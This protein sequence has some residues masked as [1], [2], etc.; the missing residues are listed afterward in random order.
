MSSNTPHGQETRDVV[1]RLW[2]TG[3]SASKIGRELNM[4]KNMIIG[5]AHR[6][7]LP[8]RP[9][10]IT[11][12]RLPVTN[13]L[14]V[15]AR[16]R[17]DNGIPIKSIAAFLGITPDAF[18]ARRKYLGWPPRDPALS[19]QARWILKP[20][21]RKYQS[22]DGAKERKAARRK[23]SVPGNPPAKAVETRSAPQG[24]EAAPVRAGGPSAPV[25]VLW[26]GTCQ[27]PF[28]EPGTK[29]F[30]F[31]DAPVEARG[32]SYCKDHRKLCWV[33]VRDVREGVAA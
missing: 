30:R 26:P 11:L 27:Y 9:C 17:W 19:F 2:A 13:P 6:M 33:R 1:E 12:S 15:E 16:L 4:T 29:S 31:C 23:G 25:T 10:P 3:L 20:Y 14:M 5:L 21:A 24:G 18:A 8:E 22:G 28:G 7:G 32:K